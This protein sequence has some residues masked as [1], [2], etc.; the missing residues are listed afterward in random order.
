MA[1]ST[2]RVG[3]GMALQDDRGIIVTAS[4]GVSVYF[5]NIRLGKRFWKAPSRHL[6]RLLEVYKANPLHG[7]ELLNT[8]CPEPEEE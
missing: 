5:K 3:H 1:R 4:N 8:L 6:P 2:V 7:I